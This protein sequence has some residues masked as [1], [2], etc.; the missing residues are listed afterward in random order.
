MFVNPISNFNVASNS[1]KNNAQNNNRM[2]S[3]QGGGGSLSG[4]A[5]DTVS[6]GEKLDKKQKASRKGNYS[7]I[8][9]I[10]CISNWKFNVLTKK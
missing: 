5:A 6:F 1:Y 10:S 9:F 3:S 2:S 4:L 8:C 7:Y